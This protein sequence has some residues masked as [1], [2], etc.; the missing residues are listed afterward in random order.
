[1][2]FACTSLLAAIAIGSGISSQ[3]AHAQS[4]PLL[5]AQMMHGERGMQN[6]GAP[7]STMQGMG[8]SGMPGMQSQGAQAAPGSTMQGMMCGPGMQSGSMMQMPMMR[9]GRM[10]D[11]PSDYI[12]G[13]IAFM[14]AELRITD[15]QMAA[16]TEFANVLRA[17]AKRSADA[18]AIQGQQTSATNADR[19]D[20]QERWLAVRLESVRALKAAY[21]KLYAVLDEKQKKT[22]D[23]LMAMPMGHR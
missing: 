1:M 12:E 11:V 10:V 8:G 3:S 6:Q 15:S 5:L 20:E 21:G 18:R 4:S 2:K 23:E 14:H 19:L 13:R 16:W 17:N 9:Q 22:A 7:G